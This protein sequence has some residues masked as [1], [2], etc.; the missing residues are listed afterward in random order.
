MWDKREHDKMTH[1]ENYACSDNEVHISA[2]MPLLFQ[3]ET[4]A[5]RR[6]SR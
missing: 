5:G 6:S 1:N 4:I 2:Q 3:S